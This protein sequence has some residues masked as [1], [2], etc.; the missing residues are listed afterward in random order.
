MFFEFF[1]ITL[2]E[3]QSIVPKISIYR[4]EVIS[5]HIQ[6]KSGKELMQLSK[7][8][9]KQTPLKLFE[10]LDQFLNGFFLIK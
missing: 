6:Q 5:E 10:F 9:V 8:K 2:L 3:K 7:I 1:L 4:A